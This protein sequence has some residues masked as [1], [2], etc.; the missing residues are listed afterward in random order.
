MGG[1]KAAILAQVGQ[2]YFGAVGQFY[3]GANNYTQPGCRRG[4]FPTAIGV[5]VSLNC[6]LRIR[7]GYSVSRL[8]MRPQVKPKRRDRNALEDP[9]RSLADDVVDAYGELALRELYQGE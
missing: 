9:A 7:D 8:R 4:R 1:Q 5:V 2:I 6:S 3:I